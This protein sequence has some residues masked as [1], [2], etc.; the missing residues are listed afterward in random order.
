MSDK[1]TRLIDAFFDAHFT[2]PRGRDFLAVNAA[3]ERG[4]DVSLFVE[5]E[6]PRL[7]LDDLRA[8]ETAGPFAFL[9]QYW[10]AKGE[11]ELIALVDD[12]K[13]LGDA[14]DEDM[15]REIEESGELSSL[16]YA[17]Y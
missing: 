8:L 15:A 2:G 9:R 5:A 1:V 10:G 11:N 13:A 17:M 7:T 4:S 6:R 14:V 3:G 12:L 16:V